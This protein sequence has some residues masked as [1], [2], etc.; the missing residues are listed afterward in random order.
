MG[1]LSRPLRFNSAAASSECRPSLA[2][3]VTRSWI[4]VR[5]LSICASVMYWPPMRPSRYRVLSGRGRKS[6]SDEAVGGGEQ[7]EGLVGQGQKAR[8][9][10]SDVR[11]EDF[12]LPLD[13]HRG[14][15]LA[16]H[17][18]AALIALARSALDEQAYAIGFAG[19]RW[20]WFS[21]VGVAGAG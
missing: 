3:S 6:V 13:H 16:L 20:R 14:R 2:Y 10:R 8:D 18:L 9:R 19:L 17:F 4:D 21:G 15:I 1:R 5:T 12:Q 11:V 7:V